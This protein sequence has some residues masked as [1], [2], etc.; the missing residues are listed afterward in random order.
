MAVERTS[1]V[2]APLWSGR[3]LEWGMV[4]AIVLVLMGAFDRHVRGVQSQG[5]LAAVKSTLGALRTA[6]VLDFLQQ[7]VSTARPHVVAQQ[8][9]PFRLLEAVPANFAGEFG[10]LHM[11]TVAPGSW[12]FDPDCSCIGY[13]PMYHQGLEGPAPTPAAWFKVGG[14]PGPL[15]ITAMETYVWQG[16][17]LK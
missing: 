13:L 15:Q 1:P 3:V 5:E 4:V 7:T 11:E 10:A 9:N 14:A 12:V 8:R 16:Q 6:L 2:A 17:V